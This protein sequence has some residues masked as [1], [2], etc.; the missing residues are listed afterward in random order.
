MDPGTIAPVGVGPTSCFVGGSAHP[1]FGGV[2]IKKEN[3]FQI[4]PSN[5]LHPQPSQIVT[6]SVVPTLH[7]NS[8]GFV[9]QDCPN[10]S[11]YGPNM[12][13]ELDSG[14]R[15]CG[16]NFGTAVELKLHFGA[17]HSRTTFECFVCNKLFLQKFTFVAHLS[18]YHGELSNS[19]PCSL[20]QK[21]FTSQA[22][23]NSHASECHRGGP[24]SHLICPFCQK[25][26]TQKFTLRRH[27]SSMHSS[28]S[29]GNLDCL[30]EE[31]G[32]P[33]QCQECGK[34]YKSQSG[35]TFHCKSKHDT[36]QYKCDICS[37]TFTRAANV[38]R[39]IET[40][41]NHSKT[42]P[43]KFCGKEFRST[44]GRDMHVASEHK[45][46]R[47]GCPNCGKQFTRK[48]SLDRHAANYCTG[49]SSTLS[50]KEQP[51]DS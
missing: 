36:T 41:H 47:F 16:V 49:H 3:N 12:E 37:K 43:C 20:C 10:D 8:T 1:Q 45:A 46:V 23:L 7:P 5:T 6:K 44:G 26:F 30:A 19:F 34:S 17:V 2:A 9:K 27:I 28:A 4:K 18:K 51:A 32:G 35:L 22:A 38:A 50:I 14:C 42:F 40:V 48:T 13:G 33:F 11:E 15:K 31:Q 21:S 25:P 39:H 24:S 29:S